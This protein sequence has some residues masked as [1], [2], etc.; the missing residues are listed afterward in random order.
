M[1]HYQSDHPVY[2]Y[3]VQNLSSV[4]EIRLLNLLKPRTTEDYYLD[5]E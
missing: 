1:Q 3:R 2:Y 4:Q 5:N